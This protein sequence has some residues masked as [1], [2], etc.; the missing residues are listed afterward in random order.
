MYTQSS[1]LTPPASR[2]HSPSP[3]H[4]PLPPIRTLP[5]SPSLSGTSRHAQCAICYKEFARPS[6]FATHLRVHSRETPFGPHYCPKCFPTNSSCITHQPLDSAEKP[7]VC[8]RCDDQ[9]PASSNLI[10]LNKH[11]PAP[12]HTTH[13]QSS[14]L[15]STA[16]TTITTTTTN[17]NTP[18][19]NNTSSEQQAQASALMSPILSANTT[20]SHSY[21]HFPSIHHQTSHPPPLSTTHTSTM[22]PQTTQPRR[23]HHQCASHSSTSA[24]A[25]P[26]AAPTPL[27][28]PSPNP[29]PI[30]LLQSTTLPMYE[31]A[32][33]LHH[34]VRMEISPLIPTS[35]FST[36]L[37]FCH[38][39]IT[40]L[41]IFGST[42]LHL[43]SKEIL[44]LPIAHQNTLSST[45]FSHPYCPNSP[46]SHTL[47]QSLLKALP[48]SSSSL[49]ASH[50]GT[51]ADAPGVATAMPCLRLLSASSQF[52]HTIFTINSITTTNTTITTI[53][54]TDQ[55]I[56]HHLPRH[57]RHQLHP[58]QPTRHPLHSFT[59][60]STLNPLR[61]CPPTNLQILLPLPLYPPL[62]SR[63]H[64]HCQSTTITQQ[65][66]SLK[67]PYS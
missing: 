27:L 38:S 17:N 63:Q 55:S 21:L 42:S 8:Q 31:L 1:P 30:A 2:Q 29:P 64:I 47:P 58:M 43:H 46:S 19:A 66:A 24:T 50:S 16:S 61:A 56:H 26:I 22:T 25:F 6:L 13:Y 23:Q 39:C 5:R 48:P 37:T 3:P 33:R 7:F 9:F 67:P 41:G 28:P 51:H 53:K 36:C 45:I 44:H 34:C 54:S 11:N 57:Q 65:I 35:F 12:P 20:T 62:H 4:S 40:W 59:P 49:H 18:T 14:R 52:T 32:P 60:V 15:A 10:N